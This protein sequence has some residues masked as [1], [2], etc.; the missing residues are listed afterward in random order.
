[1]SEVKKESRSKFDPEKLIKDITDLMEREG[2]YK[3]LD[4][5]IEGLAARMH[6][7]RTYLSRAVNQN[8]QMTFRQWLNTYRIERSIQYML[9]HPAANQEEIAHESGFLSASAFNHKFK[10]ITGT[11]PRLWLIEMSIGDKYKP[12]NA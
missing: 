12:E 6:T 11:S 3:D 1:M 7:N 10:S 9:T 5:T 2:L 8:Y 4:L